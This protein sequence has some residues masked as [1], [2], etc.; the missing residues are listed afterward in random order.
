MMIGTADCE[1]RYF[2][3]FLREDADAWPDLVYT[4]LGAGETRYRVTEVSV[5][6]EWNGG[7]NGCLQAARSVRV[8]A[9]RRVRKDQTLGYRLGSGHMYYDGS[10]EVNAQ[11]VRFRQAALEVAHARYVD[12]FASQL[13]GS[14]DA[15]T[16]LEAWRRA[17][18]L[19]TQIVGGDVP[20]HRAADASIE[21]A[22]L[23]HLLDIGPVSDATHPAASGPTLTGVPNR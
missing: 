13:T 3:S 14:R 8:K 1:F 21:L 9:A 6:V 16:V 15:G 20:R 4:T 2:V 5:E 17:R 22:T 23:F 7:Q 10:E 18:T 11:A 12:W 19:A